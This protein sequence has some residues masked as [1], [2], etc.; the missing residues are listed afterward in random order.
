VGVARVSVFVLVH[1][2]W[3]G[4]WQWRQVADRLRQ[5]GH[6][7]FT[8]TLT[9]LG[10]RSHLTE[11]PVNLSLH[12]QDVVQML[13]FEDLTDVVLV[14]WS[15]GG[16][17]VDGVADLV[18]E[19]LQHVVNLDGEVVREGVA[20][21][22]GWTEEARN[23]MRDMLE[24][25]EATGWMQPPSAD[26]MA[27][28]LDDPELRAWVAERERPQPYA[29]DTEPYPDN[30]GRRFTVRHTFLRCSDDDWQ[31]EPVVTALRSDA[32]WAFR[33][34]NLNHLGLFYASDIVADA[35]HDLAR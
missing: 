13:F 27:G 14:G 2:G 9:G 15:Y 16:A 20:L 18:P 1:G 7:V 33:E 23:A 31:E 22:E 35:L 29:T 12:I 17:V 8:P 34:L 24:Q 4:G 3:G 28:D 26:D 6:D 5:R 30:G 32:R 25:A 19:R 10:D 11:T 21:M